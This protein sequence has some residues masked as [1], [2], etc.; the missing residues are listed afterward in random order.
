MVRGRCGVADG[1]VDAM[2]Q[3]VRQGIKTA[4]KLIKN[5]FNEII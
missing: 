5:A 4:S 2:L 1:D 3:H